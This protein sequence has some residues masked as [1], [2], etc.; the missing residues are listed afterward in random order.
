[1]IDRELC[2]WSS[3]NLGYEH[4]ITPTVAAARRV[5]GGR[6]LMSDMKQYGNPSVQ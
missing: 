2:I 3:C 1:M 5:T 6:L 4:R